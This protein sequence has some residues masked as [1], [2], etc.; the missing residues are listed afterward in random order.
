MAD[1][2]SHPKP[3]ENVSPFSGKPP[4]A[5]NLTGPKRAE[6]QGPPEERTKKRYP[7]SCGI[8]DREPL[9]V[10]ARMAPRMGIPGMAPVGK[11]A[12]PSVPGPKMVAVMMPEMVTVGMAAMV[13][14]AVVSAEILSF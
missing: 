6:T 3:A 10:K 7:G 4:P 2:R 12:M 11:M 9:T 5:V 13:R 14:M 8:S 1:R